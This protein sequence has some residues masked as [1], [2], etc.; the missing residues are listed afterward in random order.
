[1]CLS[2]VRFRR[3]FVEQEEQVPQRPSQ[4]VQG[5]HHHVPDLALPRDL[6]EGIQGGPGCLCTA[7]PDVDELDGLIPAACFCSATEGVKLG[8]AVLVSGG[9]PDVEGE[10]ASLRHSGAFPVAGATCGY[11]TRLV[12]RHGCGMTP[13]QKFCSCRVLSLATSH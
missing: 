1:M 12:G 9:G 6:F 5:K 11:Q 3:E 2:S 13:V 10:V 8:G 7:V 4:A